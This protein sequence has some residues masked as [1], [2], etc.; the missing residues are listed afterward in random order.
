[1]SSFDMSQVKAVQEAISVTAA[2]NLLATGWVL[3]TVFGDARLGALH[4]SFGWTNQN[5][6]P[7]A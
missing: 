3:L 1:M 2:N 5:S 4:Y 6:P 7:P